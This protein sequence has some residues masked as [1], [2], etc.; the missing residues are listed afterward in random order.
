MEVELGF[1]VAKVAG[2]A[3]ISAS[4]LVA[5]R[6]DQS[7]LPNKVY[8]TLVSTNQVPDQKSQMSGISAFRSR[9]K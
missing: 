4:S 7:P 8:D 6:P 5:G 1:C 9:E 2:S 3:P